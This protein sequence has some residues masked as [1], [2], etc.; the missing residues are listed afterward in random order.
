MPYWALRVALMRLFCRRLIGYSLG[1]GPLRTALS[2][3]FAGLAFSLME[4]VTVRDRL[5]Q[6]L[7]QRLTSKPVRVIPDPALLI[8]P[9]AAHDVQAFLALQGVPLH[10]RPL[11]G[12]APRRWFPPRN[13]IIPHAIK[14]KFVHGE[15]Q[16]P[17]EEQCMI[18]LLARILDGM[19]KQFNAHIVFMPTYAEHHEGDVR[20]CKQIQADMGS[21]SSTL[22]RIQQPALYKGVTGELAVLLGGRM[23]PTIL[24]S[25]MGTPCVGLSYNQKFTGFFLS[26]GAADQVMDVESF[27]SRQRVDDLASML[28]KAMVGRVDRSQRIGALIRRLD[29]FNQRLIESLK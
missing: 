15:H 26:L 14:V 22:L 24:A 27:V 5:A 12:V 6:A 17:T 8:K 13:R 25:A 10:G 11:I 16:V 1:V 7:S 28:E 3:V 4:Q 20:I 19:V 9:E 29:E 18:A 23:H 2:R 21:A